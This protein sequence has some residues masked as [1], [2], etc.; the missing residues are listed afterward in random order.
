MRFYISYPSQIKKIIIGLQI[1]GIILN[2]YLP[3]RD[4]LA[5]NS[6]LYC[7]PGPHRIR[8]SRLGHFRGGKI[9]AEES[10]E[11]THGDSGTGS[12]TVWYHAIVYVYELTVFPTV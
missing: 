12:R 4:D 3:G 2:A 9:H 5:D 8:R 1:H 11:H 7:H 6:G 10:E